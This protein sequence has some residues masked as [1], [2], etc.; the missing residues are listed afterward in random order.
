M[1]SAKGRLFSLGLNVLKD[2]WLSVHSFYQPAS[3]QPGIQSTHMSVLEMAS[4]QI[5][6]L[7]INSLRP[8][9]NRRPFA[10]DIFK[11]I[12]LNKN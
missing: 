8:G 4:C 12:F 11:C 7:P 2:S 3:V 10:D 5:E 6:Y 1:S 9:L